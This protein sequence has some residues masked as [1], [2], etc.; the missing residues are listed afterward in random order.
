MYIISEKQAK[1]KSKKDK[2][3]IKAMKKIGFRWFSSWCEYRWVEGRTG[4]L[5]DFHED[6]F[7]QYYDKKNNSWERV[8]CVYENKG[9]GADNARKQSD[10]DRI[11][12]PEH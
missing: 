10:D 5:T 7:L 1:A 6:E 8:P 11:Y 12:G 9:C 3:K 2:I 4:A